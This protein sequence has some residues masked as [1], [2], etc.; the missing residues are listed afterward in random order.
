MVFDLPPASE[1]ISR[2]QSAYDSV[3]TFEEDVVGWNW[4]HPFTAHISFE[5]PGQFRAEGKSRHGKKYAILI[6]GPDAFVKGED[7][8]VQ[9]DSSEVALEPETGLSGG[10]CSAVAT[11]L[12]HTSWPE[13]AP[14]SKIHYKVTAE[15]IRGRNCYRLDAPGEHTRAMWFDQETGFSVKTKSMIFSQ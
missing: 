9:A 2:A 1:I 3:Q 5:R 8:W 7:P 14:D 11:A 15:V 10:A 12:L 6:L 4:G 13:I